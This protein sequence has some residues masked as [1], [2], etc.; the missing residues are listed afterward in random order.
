MTDYALVR[1]DALNSALA[2]LQSQPYK[3]VINVL[4]RLAM[5]HAV[6]DERTIDDVVAYLEENKVHADFASKVSTIKSTKRPK[7]HD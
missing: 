5:N 7:Q 3:D 2:Y 6:I 1:M 4:N